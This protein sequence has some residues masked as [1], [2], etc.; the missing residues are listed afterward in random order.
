MGPFTVSIGSIMWPF[1]FLTTDVTNEYFGKRM[2]R[3]LSY[4]M[5]CFLGYPFLVQ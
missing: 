2:V 4:L 5:A 3:R 1:V